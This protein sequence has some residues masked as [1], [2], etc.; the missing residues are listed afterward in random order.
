MPVCSNVGWQ[1][2]QYFPSASHP[3]T[4]PPPFCPPPP[5]PP[6]PSVPPSLT[7]CPH[8]SPVTR[9]NP[10]F[11]PSLF[12]PRATPQ[13]PT[14]TP[15]P[16]SRPEREGYVV[17]VASAPASPSGPIMPMSKRV[18]QQRARIFGIIPRVVNSRDDLEGDYDRSRPL[19]HL[20][21]RTT[22]P[23]GKGGRTNTRV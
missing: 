16:P 10:P 22:R 3:S 1:P 23:R 20:S 5:P 13:I 2:D 7:P 21:R 8:P 14:V 11:S 6:P 17:N 12:L 4:P 19:S 9:L 18:G 15:R